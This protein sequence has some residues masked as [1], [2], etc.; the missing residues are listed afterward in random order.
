MTKIGV[1]GN[2][3]SFYDE[4]HSSTI[5]SA[6]WCAERGIGIFEYSFGKGISLSDE[7]AFKIGQEFKKYG[8]ENSVH[9]PYYINFANPSRESI[10]K[11]FDF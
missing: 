9:A 1:A 4:G 5:E 6:A 7:T 2:S 10:E 3:Q 8:I 11:N